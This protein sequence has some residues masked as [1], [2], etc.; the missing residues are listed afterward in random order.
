MRV[1]LNQDPDPTPPQLGLNRLQFN[2]NLGLRSIPNQ[3]VVNTQQTIKKRNFLNTLRE[4]NSNIKVV[5]TY[6]EFRYTTNKSE[7]FLLKYIYFFS[8]ALSTDGIIDLLNKSLMV[9]VPKKHFLIQ[10][11]NWIQYNPHLLL[12]HHFV[13]QW[14]RHSLSAL[15]KN[16]D[17][18]LDKLWIFLLRNETM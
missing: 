10:W 3:L 7:E 9:N 12:H 16:F 8:L 4:K 13:A 15:L 1:S 14:F 2:W 11:R 18:R 6:F 17:E 5:F